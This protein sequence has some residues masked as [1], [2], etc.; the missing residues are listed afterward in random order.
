[1]SK[2]EIFLWKT[3]HIVNKPVPEFWLEFIKVKL[4]DSNLEKCTHQ[5]AKFSENVI[6][7]ILR[8]HFKTLFVEEVDGRHKV[9]KTKLKI[10]D[11]VQSPISKNLILNIKYYFY[12]E[13]SKDIPKE[14]IFKKFE[15]IKFKKSPLKINYS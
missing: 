14:Y 15:L 5:I 8:E 13:L 3:Y 1:M 10:K 12:I 11:Y 2:E 6:E 9:W 7:L 4:Q